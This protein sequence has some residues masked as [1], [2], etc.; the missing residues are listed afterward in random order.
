MTVAQ[1]IGILNNLP[2]DAAIELCPEGNDMITDT[3]CISDA[4]VLE[5]HIPCDGKKVTS[6]LP[7]LILRFE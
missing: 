7:V 4:I 1:L 2:M 3:Y 6:D 5:R